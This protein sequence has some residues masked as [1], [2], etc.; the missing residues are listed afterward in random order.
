MAILLKFAK[1]ACG[2]KYI[3]PFFCAGLVYRLHI[4]LYYYGFILSVCKKR[5]ILIYQIY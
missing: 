4:Y 5:I 2:V 1:N 3:I